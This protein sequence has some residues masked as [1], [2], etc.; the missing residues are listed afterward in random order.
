MKCRQDLYNEA[1]QAL[2]QLKIT[3]ALELFMK[4]AESDFNSI[5]V[6]TKIALCYQKKGDFY[7]AKEYVDKALMI[8][9]DAILAKSIYEELKQEGNYSNYKKSSKNISSCN[10]RISF[11]SYNRCWGIFDN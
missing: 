2:N 10:Y 1:E 3:K 7:R 11:S 5:D 4:C 6:N 8:D 9:G